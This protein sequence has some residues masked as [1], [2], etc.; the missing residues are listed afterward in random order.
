MSKKEIKE[1]EVILSLSL[2]DFE[3]LTNRIKSFRTS[4]RENSYI[5]DDSI[6]INFYHNGKIDIDANFYYSETEDITI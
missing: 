5:D 6:N 1:D 2:G 4:E 3:E